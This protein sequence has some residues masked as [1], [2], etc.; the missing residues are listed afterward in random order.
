M[1]YLVIYIKHSLGLTY[2]Y[3]FG[4]ETIEAN[5]IFKAVKKA[6]KHAQKMS[7]ENKTI[8]VKSVHE[9]KDGTDK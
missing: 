1:K 2:P 9:I 6:E 5:N 7:N 4:T 8:A 3:N